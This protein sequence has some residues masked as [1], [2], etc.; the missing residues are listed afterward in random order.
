MLVFQEEIKLNIEL[1]RSSKKL[2][3]SE[4]LTQE[5]V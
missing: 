5:L 3:I 2:S 1:E 4:I